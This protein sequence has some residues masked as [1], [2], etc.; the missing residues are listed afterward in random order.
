M[1][2]KINEYR[3]INEKISSQYNKILFFFIDSPYKWGKGWTE[4]NEL[5][6]EM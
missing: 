2:T 5:H 1:I 4:S 3:K 6:D